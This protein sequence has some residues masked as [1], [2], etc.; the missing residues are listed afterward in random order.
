M[1]NL[2]LF[3]WIFGVCFLGGLLTGIAIGHVIRKSNPINETDDTPIMH[4]K[5]AD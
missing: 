2:Q 5:Q 3:A 1:S 4:K